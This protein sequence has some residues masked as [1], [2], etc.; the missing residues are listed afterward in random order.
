MGLQSSKILNWDLFCVRSDSDLGSG[1]H[2]SGEILE[3]QSSVVCLLFCL[4]V[5]R[6]TLASESILANFLSTV[7]LHHNG[8]RYRFT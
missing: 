5:A 2:I 7:E 3:E 4:P 1:E 8:S 6:L